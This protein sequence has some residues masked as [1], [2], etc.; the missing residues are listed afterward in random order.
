MKVEDLLKENATVGATS[1]GNVAAVAMPLYQDGFN[2]NGHY[3]IYEKP[4]KKKES[5]PLI[6][7][8]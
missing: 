5:K 3:G 6:I 8:R 7:K 2:P 1:S 4:K